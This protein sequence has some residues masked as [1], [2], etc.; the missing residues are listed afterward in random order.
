MAD[1]MYSTDPEG[2]E[3]PEPGDF[4]D[5]QEPEDRAPEAGNVPAPDQR[6]SE[7]GAPPP[8]IPTGD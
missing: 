4:E 7:S 8:D 2:T 3:Q 6:P 1:P 5:D